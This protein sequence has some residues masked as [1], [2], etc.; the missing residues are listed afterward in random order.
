MKR[1]LI[2]AAAVVIILSILAYGTVAFWQAEGYAENI[3]TTGSLSLDVHEET[4][5]GQPFP[6]D[7]IKDVMPGQEV[8]KKVSV[9]NTGSGDMWVRMSVE[10]SVVDK[11]GKALPTDVV[12]IGNLDTVNWTLKDGYYYYNKAL[13]PAEMTPELFTTVNFAEDRVNEFRGCTTYVM[14]KAFGVQTANN[15]DTAMT[16]K[17]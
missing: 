3:I 5:N 8:T 2:V 17:W 7:G 15:G 10:I 14:V 13:K 11:E 1:K 12:S 9:Q 4:D 6:E 16:A